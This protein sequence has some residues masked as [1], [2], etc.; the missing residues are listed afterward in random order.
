MFV[1]DIVRLNA[2]SRGDDDA[3]IA[4][5]RSYTYREV[6]AA[7]DD[8]VA[9]LRARGIGHGDRVAALGRTQVEYV[10]LYYATAKLGALLVPLNVW[11]RPAEHR[12]TLVDSEPALLFLAPALSAAVAPVV[13]EL[14]IPVVALPAADDRG[15][16]DEFLA[17]GQGQEP[18]LTDLDPDDPHMVLYTSGTTGAPKGA[19]LSHRRTTEDAMAMAAAMR[20]RSTDA[21]INFF[22][23]FHVACWDHMKLYHFIG[24]RVVLLP[25]FDAGAV[26]AAIE[27][28]R[29]SCL[30]AVPTMLHDLLEH[31]SFATTDLSSL[32]LLYYGAYDPSGLMLRVAEVFG[33]RDG[34]VEM[35][36]TY[37]LTEGGPFVAI[38]YPEELFAKFGSIGRAMPGV[39]IALLDDAC[40]RVEPGEPGEICVKGPRMSGYWRRPEESVAALADG[41]LHTGDIATADAD[42]FLWI[43]DRKKDTIR[44][45]GHNVYSKEVENCLLLHGLVADCAVIGVPD[46][47]YEERVVAIVVLAGIAGDDVERTLQNYVRA[48]LAGYNVPK[49]I[50]VVDTLPKNSVGKTLK[51]ELRTIY[52]SVFD[53]GRYGAV[54]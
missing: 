11:H 9:A 24:A 33:A 19:L 10:L 15:S 29:V 13:A 18:A 39:E 30:L 5:E 8:V 3:L 32:R 20:L 49:E 45:G 12:V 14:G 22:P 4:A 21:F 54:G 25:Q 44:S 17:A 31:P 35:F 28:Y 46:P 43:V 36:H 40:S 6:D 42:G 52:G 16:W 53:R 47:V 7:I 51:H 50:H 34:R 23:S 27:R 38:C 41:W 26:L 2:L 1:G 48:Q 37:G